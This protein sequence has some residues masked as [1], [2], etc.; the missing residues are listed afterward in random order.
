MT[1]NQRRSVLLLAL[2]ATAFVP[3]AGAFSTPQFSITAETQIVSF[4]D[5]LTWVPNDGT[6]PVLAL[7]LE[8]DRAAVISTPPLGQTTRH[9][10]VDAPR[11]PTPVSD[12]PLRL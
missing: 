9:P 8:R 1:V 4:D 10:R 12:R 11:F 7:G 5:D 2:L 3:M 6:P